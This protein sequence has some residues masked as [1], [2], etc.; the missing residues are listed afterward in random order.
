MSSKLTANSVI[1]RRETANFYPSTSEAITVS[2]SGGSSQRI[3]NIRLSSPG[4]LDLQTACLEFEH[5]LTGGAEDSTDGIPDNHIASLIEEITLMVGGQRVEHIRDLGTVVN[6]LSNATESAGHRDHNGDFQGEWLDAKYSEGQD[7]NCFTGTGSDGVSTKIS[8]RQNGNKLYSPYNVDKGVA[9]VN[10]SGGASTADFG[11][12]TSQTNSRVY[13]IPLSQLLGTFSLPQYFVL[14]NIGNMTIQLRFQDNLRRC[15]V[16]LQSDGGANAPA[17][18]TLPANLV[19]TISQLRVKADIVYPTASY[20]SAVDNLL[21][22]DAVGAMFGIQTLESQDIDFTGSGG[23]SATTGVATTK[24]LVFTV[25]T[26]YLK[27]VYVVFRTKADLD[28]ASRL[29]LSAFPSMGFESA[30][31][32]INGVSYPVVPIEGAAQ[33]YDELEKAMNLLGDVDRS[34]LIP[35]A[36]YQ[37]NVSR[38]GET[39]NATV[40][41]CGKFM[42]GFNLEQ[43]LQSGRALGG[44]STLAGGYNIRL[45][46]DN[47]GARY[48][49]GNSGDGVDSSAVAT[50][51]FYKDV[52]LQIRQNQVEVSQG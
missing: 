50:G 47:Q 31:M 37:S 9:G 28:N 3:V 7:N 10:G 43:V 35:L 14:R 42:L 17:D 33:A 26:R 21:A 19:S 51:V 29:S 34:N 15:L 38:S 5:K 36:H 39:T 22:N 11:Y 8:N 20:V 1:E 48:A 41:Y 46:V 12:K 2:N 27:G 30:R 45:E 44:I 16:N 4:Y 23:T 52:I 24:S 40:D 6:M 18:Q 25:G 49:T 32:F 13:R